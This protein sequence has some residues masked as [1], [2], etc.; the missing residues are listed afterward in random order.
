MTRGRGGSGAG[1]SEF[2]IITCFI[3]AVFRLF[4]NF[5]FLK[6]RHNLADRLELWTSIVYSFLFIFLTLAVV[7]FPHVT[8][9]R[10]IRSNMNTK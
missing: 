8:I 10:S 1:V 5:F 2:R 7:L 9:F 3:V 4:T 6:N